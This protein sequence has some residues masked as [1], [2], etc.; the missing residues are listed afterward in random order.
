MEQKRILRIKDCTCKQLNCTFCPFYT[1]TSYV[2]LANGDIEMIYDKEKFKACM[3]FPM[4]TTI[5][6]AYN[7]YKKHFTETKQII[8]LAK[9]ERIFAVENNEE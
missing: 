5:G 8:M 7:R 1:S 6:Q 9:M 3:S 4:K 2:E